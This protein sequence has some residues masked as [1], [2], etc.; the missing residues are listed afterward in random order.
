[1]RSGMWGRWGVK[2][3]VIETGE[4]DW[5]T[6]EFHT[7]QDAKDLADHYNAHSKTDLHGRPVSHK[8]EE[9]EEEKKST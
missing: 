5:Y 6:N 9:H 3:T 2:R 8:A 1:M 7:E 4:S